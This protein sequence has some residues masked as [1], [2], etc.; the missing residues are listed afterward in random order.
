MLVE[1]SRCKDKID[2]LFKELGYKEIG[3][4]RKRGEFI[5]FKNLP[6]FI[7]NLH[8]IDNFYILPEK[9]KQSVGIGSVVE[10]ICYCKESEKEIYLPIISQIKA[11]LLG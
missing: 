3:K 4:I 11:K 10:L 2:D 8:L 5:K 9:E 7:L 1:F 6:I